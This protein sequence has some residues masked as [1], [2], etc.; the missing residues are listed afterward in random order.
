MSQLHCKARD[1]LLVS[2]IEHSRRMN[3]KGSSQGRKRW[4]TMKWIAMLQDER[5]NISIFEMTVGLFKLLPSGRLR[6]PEDY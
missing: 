3:A 1:M 2:T 4:K 5:K 6:Y